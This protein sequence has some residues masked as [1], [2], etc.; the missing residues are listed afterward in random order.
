MKWPSAQPRSLHVR[1]G[2]GVAYQTV[3]RMDEAIDL[4]TRTQ[5]DSEQV[6]GPD[7]TNTLVTRNNL[8]G[9]YQ[10][11]GRMDE[12]IG[13]YTRTLADFERVLGPD[14]P[15]TLLSR[16]NLEGAVAEYTPE[17]RCPTN[18]PRLQD[19]SQA[20]GSALDCHSRRTSHVVASG[21]QGVRP[22]DPGMIRA[23]HIS[24]LC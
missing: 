22:Y 21:R 19:W 4:Y 15:T 20:Y 13:L 10:A 5:A 3:G 2:V 9:A 17:Q 12:A 24:N 16:S 8:A 7:H 1:V 18:R 6:L 11:M 23:G 14:H